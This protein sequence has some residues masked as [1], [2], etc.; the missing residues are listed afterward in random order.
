MPISG[1]TD[2]AKVPFSFTPFGF[3]PFG[4]TPF[5]FTPFGFTPVFSFTPFGF[6]PVAFG[7][8]PFGF[9]PAPAFGFTPMG[10]SFSPTPSFSFSFGF[11]PS[12][13]TYK[14]VGAETL[15]RTPNGLVAAQDLEVDQDVLSMD[16]DTLPTYLEGKPS[17]YPN[18]E[19]ANLQGTITTTKVRAMLTRLTEKIVIINGE[20]YSDTH[21][22]LINRDGI[23]KFVLVWDVLDTDMIYSAETSDW[24]E[25]YQLQIVENTSVPVVCI[26]TEPYDVFFTEKALVHDSHP[27]AYIGN[28]ELF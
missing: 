2:S 10:F 13:K 27:L 28:E 5:G 12:T 18:W 25:I 19:T 8:T 21:Y 9:T 6:T 1:I 17:S 7:F 14:S 3:T 26:N 24:V 4:F 20:T 15:I 11:Y 16:I 23:A 22:I